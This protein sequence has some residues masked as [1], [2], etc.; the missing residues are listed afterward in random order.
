MIYSTNYLAVLA[1]AVAAMALGWAWYS[2]YLFGGIW[3][4]ES[5]HTAADLEAM[6]KTG[7]AARAYALTFIGILVSAFVL[8]LFVNYTGALT[9][10]DGAMLGFWIWLGFIAPALLGETL[11]SGRSWA[12]YLINAGN[13]L[14]GIVAMGM[15]LASWS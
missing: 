4:R 13:H 8:A 10:A 11:F 15:I 9:A 1:A 2:P 12:L 7:G 14:L 5:G 3:M 6:R